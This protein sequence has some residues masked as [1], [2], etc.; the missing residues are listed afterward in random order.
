MNGLLIRKN[1]EVDKRMS[2]CSTQPLLSPIAYLHLRHSHE[3]T[4]HPVAR[5]QLRLQCS[6]VCDVSFP[7]LYL[8]MYVCIYV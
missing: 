1:H 6:L 8:C 4:A 7:W 5:P 2:L 3:L